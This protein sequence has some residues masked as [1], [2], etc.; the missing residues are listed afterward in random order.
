MVSKLERLDEEIKGIQID[1][2]KELEQKLVAEKKLKEVNEELKIIESGDT[3][4]I[5]KRIKQEI[6]EMITKRVADT[7]EIK[8]KVNQ[9]RDLIVE[10][11]FMI[12]ELETLLKLY[13]I[14]VKGI[15]QLEIKK[16]KEQIEHNKSEIEKYKMENEKLKDD[17]KDFS[18]KMYDLTKEADELRITLGK[19]TNVKSVLNSSLPKTPAENARRPTPQIDIPKGKSNIKE[20][21]REDDY[22][23]GK[24]N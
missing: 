15:M 9:S 1:I 6:D 17:G 24:E 18:L 7:V 2:D 11:E 12:N 5:K 4:S 14:E 23:A 21:S 8:R 22:W 10:R 19:Y 16:L 20:N 13:K 3:E